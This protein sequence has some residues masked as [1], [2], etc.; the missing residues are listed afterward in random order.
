MWPRRCWP[1]ASRSWRL[2]SPCPA[3]CACWSKSGP[4]GRPSPARRGHRAG[5]RNRSSSYA[6][7]RRV[8]CRGPVR[9]LGCDPA[10]PTLRQAGRPGALTPTEVV[11]AWEA[12][13]DRQGLP[14]RHH[15]P[16]LLEGDFTARCPSSP[17]ADGRSQLGHGRRLPPSRRLC[18]GRGRRWSNPKRSSGETSTASNRWLNNTFRS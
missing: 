4:L 18:A 13:A 1:A 12:G 15:G 3:Q 5:Q 8:H 14:L 2:P 11:T 9:Q 6:G 17:H 16:Q 7:R 10:L